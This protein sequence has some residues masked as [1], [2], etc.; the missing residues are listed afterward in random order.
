MASNELAAIMERVEHLSPAEQLDL[1]A[2]PR[3]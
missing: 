3:G 2:Y 1:I